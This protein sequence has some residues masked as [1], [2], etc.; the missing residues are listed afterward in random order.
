MTTDTT[1]LMQEALEAAVTRINNGPNG[2]GVVE[3]PPAPA[4]TIGA[5]MSA[6]PKLLGSNEANEEIVE[7]LDALQ[8]SGIAPLREHVR[9]L[10]KQCALMMKSQEQLVA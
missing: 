5:V 9:I 1:K 2:N 7:K 6:L 3:H 4:D 10:R 8:T